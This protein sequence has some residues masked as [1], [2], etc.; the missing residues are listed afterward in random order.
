MARRPHPHQVSPAGPRVF[1]IPPPGRPGASSPG[2]GELA[3]RARDAR[4]RLED[5][6]GLFDPH[7]ND[8]RLRRL[9]QAADPYAPLR[10]YL[11]RQA[12]GQAVTN[13][14]LK[15]YELAAHFDFPRRLLGPGGELRA[16]FNAE[17]P[18]AFV[19]ALNHF[20][21]VRYPG[22]RLEWAA[23]S[24]WPGEGGALGDDFGLC[25][26]NPDRWLMGPG[27]LGDVTDAAGLA[28]LVAAARRRLGGAIDFY[29]SD[30]GFGF[31]G[32]EHSRCEE[33][34]AR[35]HLGQVLA[36]L[37]L[38][39]EGGTLVAKTFTF[40]EPFS[41]ALLGEA[42]AL[43]EELLV[44]KPQTSRPRNSEVYLVGLG[45]RGAPRAA[46]ARWWEA[47]AQFGFCRPLCAVEAPH[48]RAAWAAAV[49]A[50]EALHGRAQVGHLRAALRLYLDYREGSGGEEAL[51]AKLARSARRAR[52]GWLGA[53]PVP[54]LPPG[55]ALRQGRPPSSGGG[56]RPAKA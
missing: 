23:S 38:L 34:A 19:S 36:G 27:L 44:V 14:W 32:D 50:A 46:L 5:A 28:A 18:G 10:G 45:Y 33:L 41:V 2:A 9:L 6:K 49:E 30:V 51:R 16:F 25:A 52:Q 26:G 15:M 12:K 56:A 42:A 13:A 53:F 3:E 31:A 11:R 22:A 48:M 24:L 17:L 55:R 47:L 39:R 20:L 54:E 21:A 4:R 43:F 8:P 40:F 1:Q 37:E 35:A 29:S 7:E